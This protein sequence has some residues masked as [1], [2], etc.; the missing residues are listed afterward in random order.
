MKDNV[1]GPCIG[2][3]FWIQCGV[4][5]GLLAMSKNQG[6][7]RPPPATL[8]LLGLALLLIPASAAVA[9]SIT[10]DDW[11]VGVIVD[12]GY[13]NQRDSQAFVTLQ[14]PF[15][16]G[17]EAN[18]GQSR[19]TAWYDFSWTPQTGVGS[20]RIDTDQRAQGV[21]S[22]SLETDSSGFIWFSQRRISC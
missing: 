7:R 16:D 15:M 2:P 11:F 3:E 14:N 21:P 19:S 9:N 4:Y 8:S 5:K 1:F 10:I 17:H 22:S 13:T 12:N 18:V 20:F 6:R